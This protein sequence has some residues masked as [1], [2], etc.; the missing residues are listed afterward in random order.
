MIRE[1]FYIYGIR[2]HIRKSGMLGL[3][4]EHPCKH[5]NNITE[6]P[7][8]RVLIQNL[9]RPVRVLMTLYHSAEHMEVLTIF[10]PAIKLRSN[11]RF[12]TI[13]KYQT[14]A[15]DPQICELLVLFIVG[16]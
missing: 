16:H 10:D 11:S 6:R 4:I 15:F 12:N 13:C 7:E 1:H 3:P 8:L 2:E 14:G 9:Y 5:G